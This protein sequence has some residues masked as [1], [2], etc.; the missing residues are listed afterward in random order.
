MTS[1]KDANTVLWMT[2]MPQLEADSKLSVTVSLK[3]SLFV[4]GRVYLL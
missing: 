3:L 2:F 1:A 4:S